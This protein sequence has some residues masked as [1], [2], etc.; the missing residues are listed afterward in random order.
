[1]VQTEKR[2]D[3]ID[4]DQ[5]SDGDGAD[6]D[7]DEPFDEVDEQGIESFPASDPPAH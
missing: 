3:P 1:M 2:P 7:S 6:P 4:G 5:R